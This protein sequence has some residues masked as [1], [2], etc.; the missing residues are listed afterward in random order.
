MIIYG[1]RPEVRSWST[2]FKENL[3]KIGVKCSLVPVE[4]SVMLKRMEDREFVAFTGGW[5][6]DFDGDPYQIFHSSQ[7]D[8]PKEFQS[9]RFSQ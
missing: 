6:L 7:A 1:Y 3:Y 8:L 4:W 5:G 2:L 9:C